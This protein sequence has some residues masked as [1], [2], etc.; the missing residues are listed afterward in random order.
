MKLLILI[1]PI[2][3]FA[4]CDRNVNA[5][6]PNEIDDFTTGTGFTMTECYGLSMVFEFNSI[7]TAVEMMR[8]WSSVYGSCEI[9]ADIHVKIGN[10]EHTA[11]FEDFFKWMGFE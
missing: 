1:L 11:S 10:E 4:G 9:K 3:L 2:I 8:N 5:S 6:E 7:P